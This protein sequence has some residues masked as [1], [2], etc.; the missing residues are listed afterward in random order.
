MEIKNSMH[1]MLDSGVRRI[2]GAGNCWYSNSSAKRSI[3]C[4]HDLYSN[5]LY[6]DGVDGLFQEELSCFLEFY[7]HVFKETLQDRSPLLFLEMALF[8]D[9]CRCILTVAAV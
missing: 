5:I 2:K 9:S 6:E 3:A 1:D 7:N 8:S 4:F